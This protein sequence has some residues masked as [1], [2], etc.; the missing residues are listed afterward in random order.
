MQLLLFAREAVQIN[1]EWLAIE[2]RIKKNK[3]EKKKRQK[4]M[5]AG[6]CVYRIVQADQMGYDSRFG[7]T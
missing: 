1:T 7:E 3:K 4:N 6:G 5:S 2:K